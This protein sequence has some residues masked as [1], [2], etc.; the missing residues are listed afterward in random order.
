MLSYFDSIV[1]LDECMKEEE[2]IFRLTGRRVRRSKPH[3]YSLLKVIEEIG[4]PSPQCG[5][6]GDV[7]DDMLAA[8]AA[9]EKVPILAIGFLSG[10]PQKRNLKDALAKAGAD[11]IIES[12]EEFFQLI[13]DTK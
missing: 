1:T 2:R 4:L 8:K 5:Y 6:V 11:L 12:P 13:S 3:P 10:H 9:R 7:V